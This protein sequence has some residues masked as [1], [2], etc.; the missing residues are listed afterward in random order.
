MIKWI[1]RLVILAACAARPP[2][3]ALADN[4]AQ[5]VSDGRAVAPR[6]P[7]AAA[8][9]AAVS[10]Y[11]V[12]PLSEM[13]Y[14]PDKAPA[15]GEKGGVVRIV[16]AKGEYEPGSF[17][18]VSDVDLGKVRLEVGDLK[19]V[20]RVG[21]GG[22]G[23]GERET[24]V[25]FPRANIDLKNVK[26]WYQNGNGWISYFLDKKLSLC[27]E[28]LLNDEDLVKVDTE[29]RCNYARLTEK[30][31]SVSYRWLN[32]PG[33]VDTRC[34]ETGNRL[35]YR[36]IQ[37]S[38]ACMRE[39]FSDATT[40]QGVTLAK[41]VHK[42]IFLTVRVAKDQP[43]GLYRGEIRIVSGH[44]TGDTRRERLSNP[45]IQQSN[46][47]TIQ[48]IP[49]SLRILDFELPAPA[50][51]FDCSKPFGTR[52]N[53][54]ISMDYILAANGGDRALAEK[55]MVAILKDF[56]AHGD[57]NPRYRDRGTHPEWGLAA[58]QDFGNEFYSAG[59]MGLMEKAEARYDARMRRRKMTELC[60]WHRPY[61]TWNNE[62]GLAMLRAIR[63]SGMVR[64][65]QEEGFRYALESKYGY[66][67]EA[68]LTD[69]Y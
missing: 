9:W 3:H 26:V 12:D 58:G 49:V 47:P 37:S 48:T 22:D 24:G 6:P 38:F 18:L 57:V 60:G 19:Q 64:I 55:Q 52:F 66:E 63:D 5:S 33:E 28:L 50:T 1:F 39:N 44:E 2:Y 65:Y 56:V 69:L 4:A 59:D 40:F 32:P 29:K 42:Q 27:P 7:H 62:I 67:S 31:G 10:W 20:E 41:G 51:Y 25:V 23:G 61:L 13:R 35:W 54:Y 36:T 21:G 14:M 11:A 43:A 8:G 17:V 46:N 15:N 30:D 53:Q 34:E 45:T 16:A 68:Q